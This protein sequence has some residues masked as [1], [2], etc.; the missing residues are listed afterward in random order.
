MFGADVSLKNIKLSLLD[1]ITVMK[2]KIN[3]ALEEYSPLWH[4]TW[5]SVKWVTEYN[6]YINGVTEDDIS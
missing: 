5:L 6:S 3:L 2:L 4:L 1:N